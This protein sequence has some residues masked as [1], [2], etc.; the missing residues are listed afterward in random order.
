MKLEKVEALN[1]NIETR[2]ARLDKQG[3]REHPSYR[4]DIDGLR[5]VAILFVVVFHAYP[6]ALPG[7]FVGVDIF[8]VISGYLISSIIF[9]ELERGSFSFLDFYARRIRRIFPALIVVLS[10]CFAFGWSTLFTEEF[11]QLG[12][13]MAAGLAFVQNI[14]LYKEAG[15]FDTASELKPLMHLWSL[16]VEEQFYMLFPLILW[17]SWRFRRNVATIIGLIFAISF[18]LNVASIT[19]DPVGTFFLP[20]TRFWEMLAGSLLAYSTLFHRPELMGLLKRAVFRRNRVTNLSIAEHDDG[21]LNDLLS[22]TGF[23]LL[24]LSATV[25]NKDRLFPGWWPLLPVSGALLII[26]AGSTARLNKWLLSNRW[27]VGIG[28]VSYPFY[29][30]HWPLLS[31]TYV[32]ESD[33][34]SGVMRGL[35]VAVSLLLAWITYRVVETPV[36]FGKRIHLKTAALCLLALLVGFAGFNTWKRN[37]LEFRTATKAAGI[38]RFD[39]P[40]RESCESLTGVKGF[41]DDDW[42]NAGNAGAEPDFVVVGDSVSNA[43]S[44]MF[45][46]LLSEN[47]SQLKF[48]QYA[49]GACP[50]LIGYGPTY[51]RDIT[52]REVNYI[53][54]TPSIKAVIISANWSDY[55]N[56]K[57]WETYSETSDS[58]KHAFLESIRLY[59]SSGKKVIVLLAPPKGTNPKSCVNRRSTAAERKADCDLTL[60]QAKNN[61][62]NYRE[63]MVPTISKMEVEYFDPFKYLCDA[64]KCRV[65]DGEKILYADV[66]HMSIFGGLYLANSGRNELVR[67]LGGAI[68][69]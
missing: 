32:L 60:Q 33:L 50:S 43:Y 13:H 27:I 62:G 41:K 51:C 61:D 54:R 42:C 64:Q 66:T 10:A 7:G 4:H 55:F 20:H 3:H 46:S 48:K 5:A 58:F 68:P 37:G 44:P 56:G 30:W 39:T 49:K 23:S 29:L 25:I 16:G 24:L 53:K 9:K 22:I 36:R 14:V 19:S 8:F 2:A 67:L 6:A 47:N 18:F 69:Q 65:A 1:G 59:Q 57:A 34:P 38:N 17:F 15:Y 31:F 45:A 35:A 28:L 26:L 40:Y 52:N 11:K 21:R 12:K 63:W